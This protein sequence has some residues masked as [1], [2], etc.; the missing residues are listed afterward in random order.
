MENVE[1][2]KSSKK[3][4]RSIDKLMEVVLPL[5]PSHLQT[6]VYVFPIL[7]SR[8]QSKDTARMQC[9]WGNEGEKG[10]QRAGEEDETAQSQPDITRR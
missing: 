5:P 9:G 8:Q 3:E 2:F 4:E 7:P 1:T 6:Y 10:E